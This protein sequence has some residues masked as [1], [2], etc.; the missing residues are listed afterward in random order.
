MLTREQVAKWLGLDSASDAESF[1]DLWERLEIP[2]NPDGT[3]DYYLIAEKIEQLGLGRRE[4]R[5]G[6]V[7]TQREVARAFGVSYHTIRADWRPRGMP[8]QTGR[9]DLQEIAAWK[10]ENVEEPPQDVAFDPTLGGT[11]A[12][13]EQQ[14][15]Q[16]WLERR[17]RAE[18][19]LKEEQAK[20]AAR[21]N[22]IA[23]A[24]TCYKPDVVQHWALMFAEIKKTLLAIPEQLKPRFPQ[25]HAQQFTEEVAIQIRNALEQF[26]R[27]R[28]IPPSSN[29]DVPPT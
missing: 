10:K 11:E 16:G 28:P 21:E 20:A 5:G 19:E 27:F 18:A 22:R 12:T 29:S 6:I 3:Y 17:R 2:P 9:Y 23:E 15:A 7:A 24:N 26:A 14:W 13:P 1:N 4:V 25:E 8:G